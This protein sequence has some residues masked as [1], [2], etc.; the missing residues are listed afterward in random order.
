ML[1]YNQHFKNKVTQYLIQIAFTG[2]MSRE[3]G[4][5]W[6]LETYFAPNIIEATWDVHSSSWAGVGAGYASKTF[7][8]TKI[9]L[10]L[11]EG[12]TRRNLIKL[13]VAVLL[14]EQDYKQELP[15]GFFRTHPSALQWGQSQTSWCFCT[16]HPGF[17]SQSSLEHWQGSIARYPAW[18]GEIEAGNKTKH[19]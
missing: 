10:Y 11:T 18:E 3:G 13:A 8:V 2:V 5:Y 7:F 19:H 1:K 4:K 14:E 9:I 16:S 6:I 12:S 17:S 15:G